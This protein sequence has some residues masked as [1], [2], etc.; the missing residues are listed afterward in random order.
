[1]TVSP[2]T[3]FEVMFPCVAQLQYD[4]L[5]EYAMRAVSQ[6]AAGML[7]DVG[8]VEL[9][10][11]NVSARQ[12]TN[13]VVTTTYRWIYRAFCAGIGVQSWMVR[14]SMMETMTGNVDPSTLV[15]NVEM[16][17]Y[18]DVKRAWHFAFYIDVAAPFDTD[19]WKYEKRGDNGMSFPDPA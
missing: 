3:T 1:M 17:S 2:G 16:Y 18:D 12:L 10:E 8:N 5:D 15:G 9:V 19:D 14:L 13:N 4:T 11:R 7:T 6:Y